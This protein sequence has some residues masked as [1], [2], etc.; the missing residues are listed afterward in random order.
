LTS[1]AAGNGSPDMNENT[2]QG[3]VRLAS[4]V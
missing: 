1:P 3:G 2:T 4:E